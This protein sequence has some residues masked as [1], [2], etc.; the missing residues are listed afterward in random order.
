MKHLGIIIFERI[1][2]ETQK[3]PP[4]KRKVFGSVEVSERVL[5]ITEAVMTGWS[6]K[7]GGAEI[8]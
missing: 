4:V 5:A 2:V 7:S 1:G 6:V 3:N 8:V